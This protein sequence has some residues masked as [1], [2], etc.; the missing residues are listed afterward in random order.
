MQAL[1]KEKAALQERKKEQYAVYR[2]IRKE[3]LEI[4]KLIQNRDSFLRGQ[5]KTGSRDQPDTNR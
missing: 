5:S 2:E 4:G 1:K 3:W